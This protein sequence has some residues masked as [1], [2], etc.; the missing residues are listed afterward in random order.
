MNNATKSVI[1]LVLAAVLGWAGYHT[2]QSYHEIQT[3]DPGSG[4]GARMMRYGFVS[5]GTLV[6]L[7]MFMA[8]EFTQWFGDRVVK[9]LYND[10]AGNA[11]RN[12]EYERADAAWSN[13]DHLGA[14]QMFR[15]YL[16]KN[17]R[18][19]HAALRI[20]EIY[21]KDLKNPLAAALELEEVLKHKLHPERWG[22]TAIRLANLYSGRLKNLKRAVE[23][24]R[25]VE[26]RYPD[27]K[28]AEKARGRLAQMDSGTRT[29]TPTE[30]LSS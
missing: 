30:E 6:L 9:V 12:A 1:C 28:A 26:S 3:A 13:G 11:L 19:I 22:W 23:L 20:A 27:T 2:L 15:D 21:E 8:H 25:E 18:E 17:P 5:F 7:G 14:I 10:D 24:L 29:T 16:K 4:A